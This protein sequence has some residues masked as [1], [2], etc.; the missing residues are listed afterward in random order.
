M[1]KNTP[2]RLVLAISATLLLTISATARQ[3]APPPGPG[4]RAASARMLDY[5]VGR[6]DVF[7]RFGQHVAISEIEVVADGCGILESYYGDPGPAGGRYIGSGLHAFDPTANLWRQIFTDNRPGLTVMIGHDA[8]PDFV[9]EWEI[10]NPL[11][12]RIP[13]RYTLQQLD[14]DTQGGA[15]V[16]QFGERSNDGGLTWILEY[17][18]RYVPARRRH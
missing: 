10:V 17:D 16:R 11:G 18:L 12:Q 13:K 4:C 9:Y 7:N 6:W 14:P 5:W 3:I 15:R 8:G 1:M 2:F